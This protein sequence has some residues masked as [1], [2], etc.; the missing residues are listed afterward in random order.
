MCSRRLLSYARFCSG[1][2]LLRFVPTHLCP[3][4]FEIDLSG[5]LSGPPKGFVSKALSHTSMPHDRSHAL[6][7]SF[8]SVCGGRSA[9]S[10]SLAR[11]RRRLVSWQFEVR[12]RRQPHYIWFHDMPK[13]AFPE[14]RQHARR[15][16]QYLLNSHVDRCCPNR[17]LM[18]TFR[19]KIAPKC[20]HPC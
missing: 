19:G 10:A 16:G 7:L 15:I 12:F 5:R 9:R 18:L 4:H 17:A 8:C 11:A 1:N 3:A 13:N 20:L 2:A 6:R 14:I